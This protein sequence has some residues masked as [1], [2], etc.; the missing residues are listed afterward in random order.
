[1]SHSVSNMEKS[2]DSI[3]EEFRELRR[4]YPGSKFTGEQVD[5]FEKSLSFQFP[6]D[7]RKT[8]M[9]G[10]IDKCTFHFIEP[11]RLDTLPDFVAFATWN[12]DI[13]LFHPQSADIFVVVPGLN[14]EKKFS[15]FRGWLIMVLECCSTSMNPE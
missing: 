13:F 12:Q 8:V 1:M 4:M 6:D 3:L 7:Y 10:D 5:R 14:P 15:S 9:A 11:Y 2:V